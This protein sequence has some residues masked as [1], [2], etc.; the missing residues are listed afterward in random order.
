MIYY[1]GLL[2][3]LCDSGVDVPKALV[4]CARSQEVKWGDSRCLD[5][6]L[7]EFDKGKIG[8]VP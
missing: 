7:Y 2:L 8:T 3:F 5:W 4:D 6:F 1:I